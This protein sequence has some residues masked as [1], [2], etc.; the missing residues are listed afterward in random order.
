MID[1]LEKDVSINKLDPLT[2]A[3]NNAFQRSIYTSQFKHLPNKYNI[4]EYTKFLN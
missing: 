3:Q 2:G 4:R 1:E